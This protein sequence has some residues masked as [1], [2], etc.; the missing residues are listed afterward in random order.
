MEAADP[1]IVELDAVPFFA[2]DGDRR[3]EFVVDATA[4]GPIE[5]P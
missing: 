5:N 3:G 2:A 4:I 1:L